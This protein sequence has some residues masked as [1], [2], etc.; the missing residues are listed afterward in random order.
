MLNDQD[1]RRDVSL[2]IDCS[3]KPTFL[4]SDTSYRLPSS[5]L[6]PNR[7]LLGLKDADP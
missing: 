7:P 5:G 2:A 3:P 4:M 1:L 6:I